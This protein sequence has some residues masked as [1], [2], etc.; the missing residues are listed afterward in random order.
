MMVVAP[1]LG[2]PIGWM[3]RI[4]RPTI[5]P[6]VALVTVCL[7]LFLAAAVTVLAQRLQLPEVEQLMIT[8]VGRDVVR[9]GGSGD[10]TPSQ[11]HDA[12]R[13]FSELQLGPT[14]PAPG[15]VQVVVATGLV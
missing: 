4:D 6:D 11:T 3:I 5:N 2:S 8:M 12:E 15:V 1:P 10:H 14:L 7:E 13:M 9:Q